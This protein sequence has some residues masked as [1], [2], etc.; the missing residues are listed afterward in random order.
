LKAF[1]SSL[2]AFAA[3]SLWASI[4][5]AQSEAVHLVW[6][7]PVG[8]LCPSRAAIESDVEALIGR[9][10]FTDEPGARVTLRGAIQDGAS[11]ARVRLEART[12]S[13]AVTGMRELSAEP[14]RCASLRDSIALVLTM[15]LDREDEMQVE[16]LGE[17]RLRFG[18]GASGSVVSTPMPRSTFTAG[19]SL[20][21]EVGS[22][23]R[24]RADAAYYWPVAIQTRG[25]VGTKL[26][27]FSVALRACLG[28]WGD[29][30]MFGLR[31]CFGTEV[32]AL[33]ASPIGL[34]GPAKQTRLLAQ[35]SLD[36]RWE[37]QLGSF[38]MFDAAVGPLVSFSRPEFSYIR[39]DNAQ[40]DVYRPALLGIIFQITFIILG[41]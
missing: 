31:V 25:G 17:G 38:A 20:S 19:P 11:E 18:I 35:G 2:V 16:A 7:R 41:S 40:M 39:N 27:A 4:A 30:R 21:L 28:L 10:V 33:I 15:F 24:F 32:G 34:E 5:F 29:P 1:L 36:F 6:E 12:A 23:L 3:S 9:K 26:Q 8:S 14:G 13:G 37:K 22:R